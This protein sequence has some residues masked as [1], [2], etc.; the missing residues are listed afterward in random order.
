MGHVCDCGSGVSSHMLKSDGVHDSR[1]GAID[2]GVA[3]PDFLDRG[4]TDTDRRRS[5]PTLSDCL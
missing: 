5:M 4:D 3:G 2:L 1:P